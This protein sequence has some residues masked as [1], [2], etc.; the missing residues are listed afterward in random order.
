MATGVTR[1][2]EDRTQTW[3]AHGGDFA[4]EYPGALLD[5]IRA[6]AVRGALQLRRGGVEVGGLLFG[7]R[8]RNRIRIVDHRPFQ[9]EH[10]S[11]PGF[12]LSENDHA[13]LRRAIDG[14]ADDEDLVGLELV[15]WYRSDSRTGPSL[16]STDLQILERAFPAPLDVAV[17][18]LPARAGET[19]F[20][21]RDAAGVIHGGATEA[22]QE[23]LDPVIEPAP[24]DAAVALAV[25]SRLRLRREP[26]RKP[27]FRPAWLL[28]SL[29]LGAMG[30]GVLTGVVRIAGPEPAAAP[31]MNLRA[32]DYAGEV[33]IEWDRLSEPV[34]RAQNAS[35]L[36]VDGDRRMELALRPELLHGGNLVYHRKSADVE[37]R[38]RVSSPRGETSQELTR[39][40]GLPSPVSVEMARRAAADRIEAPK[41]RE[42]KPGE[43]K[44]VPRR[45]PEPAPPPPPAVPKPEPAPLVLAPPPEPVPATPEPTPVAAAPKPDPPRLAAPAPRPV[46]AYRGPRTGRL[47]WTG[48]L[49]SGS[50]LVIEANRPS[51]GFITGSL[52]PAPVRVRAHP[53]SFSRSGIEV[54]ASELPGG[55]EASEQPSAINGWTRTVYKRNAR[56]A[57]GLSV[58]E[59]PSERN[60]WRKIALRAGREPLSIIVV[61]WEV[62][63]E[64]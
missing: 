44:A 42:P 55:K 45:A 13:A 26:P 2:P 50:S 64:E 49:E 51:T 22:A 21:F 54:F 3:I 40:V 1:G 10:A 8:R 37:I 60:N 12:Q 63:P 6:E 35:V 15:G 36:I 56:R 61:D 5:T 30:I 7:T 14:A 20:Y 62:V 33:R 19:G 11:G 23:A 4:I 53:A 18:V 43:P 32:A 52:P 25:P 34:A 17:I 9:S 41:P 39:L 16:S 28:F 46:P 59:A 29:M 47:I 38:L 58:V 24:A 57:A 27:P 31:G 48:A